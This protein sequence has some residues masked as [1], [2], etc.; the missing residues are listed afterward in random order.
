MNWKLAKI[1]LLITG[2]TINSIWILGLIP[3]NG[4]HFS[5]FW[6]GTTY[7]I[8][9]AATSL[10]CLMAFY[11]QSLQ[12]FKIQT[13]F[14][15]FIFT[16]VVVLFISYPDVIGTGLF[17]NSA[18][19]ITE[20]LIFSIGIGVSEELLSRGI[21]FA[22]LRQYGLSV[23]VFVS[24]LHFGLL[25]FSNLYGGQNF[26]NTLGQ[27]INAAAFGFLCASLLIFTG[28][29]WFPILLHSL[30]DWQSTIESKAQYVHDLTQQT[31]WLAISVNSI[32]Y[33]FL[34][35]TF[36]YLSKEDNWAFLESGLKKLTTRSLGFRKI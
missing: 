27:V 7:H 33:C 36:L 11:P 15:K 29:I 10:I 1:F 32:F 26:S 31:N 22:S 3:L 28:N 13:K 34:A 14:T 18:G 5:M 12:I 25:H 21:I 24:S 23:A 16:L 8:L 20:G 35:F 6:S 2:L 19:L 30:N 17:S 4:L 9:D